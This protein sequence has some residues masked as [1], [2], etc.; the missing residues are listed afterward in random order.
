[1]EAA[2]VGVVAADLATQLVPSWQPLLLR[3]RC[4]GTGA[5][6]LPNRTP[7]IL[8]VVT[9]AAETCLAVQAGTRAM[10]IGRLDFSWREDMTIG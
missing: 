4:R 5:W 2:P 3:W 10:T 6:V 7:H 1:M 9:F 8:V